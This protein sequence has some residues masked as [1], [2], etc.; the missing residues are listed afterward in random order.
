ML[1]PP[2]SGSPIPVTP[3][4]VSLQNQSA[5]PLDKTIEPLALLASSLKVVNSEFKQDAS[6]PTESPSPQPNSTCTPQPEHL[7]RPTHHPPLPAG[8][9]SVSSSSSIEPTNSTG[10]HAGTDMARPLHRIPCPSPSAASEPGS[11]D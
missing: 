10:T 11:P 6:D 7:P 2:P 8:A 5:R 9:A 4:N 1:S 3:H